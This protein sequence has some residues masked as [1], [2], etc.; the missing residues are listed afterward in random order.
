MSSCRIRFQFSFYQI[1]QIFV[2]GFFEHSPLSTTPLRV[3]VTNMCLSN[4]I[5]LTS[6]KILA[7]GP[8]LIVARATLHDLICNRTMQSI[9]IIDQRGT[10]KRSSQQS[11]QRTFNIYI[12]VLNYVYIIFVRLAPNLV[13]GCICIAINLRPQRY[14]SLQIYCS[15]SK[16]LSVYIR[17]VVEMLCFFGGCRSLKQ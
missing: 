3:L 16:R 10:N 13:Y 11:E 2:Y 5:L 14:N 12:S 7:S 4:K 9:R 1:L 17:N 8:A 6:T 15:Q